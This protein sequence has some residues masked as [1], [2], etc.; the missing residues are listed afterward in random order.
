MAQL[1]SDNGTVVTGANYTTFVCEDVPNATALAVRGT[2]PT[3]A[4]GGVTLT[5]S[6]TLAL[7][8]ADDVL[9]FRLYVDHGVA[10]A[11]WQHGRVVFTAHA[12]ETAAAAILLRHTAGDAPVAVAGAAG[13][14]MDSIWVDPGLMRHPPSSS[15]AAS[16]SFS[17]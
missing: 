17:P 2:W 1:E 14:A 10:E 7:T 8:P 13:W 5:R 11:Y 16:V 12:P 9:S 15:S 6:A 4:A 3:G